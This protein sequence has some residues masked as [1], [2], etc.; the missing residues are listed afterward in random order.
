MLKIDD[1]EDDKIVTF[2]ILG[3]IYSIITIYSFIRLMSTC[4]FSSDSRLARYFYVS[5]FVSSMISTG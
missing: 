2:V 4:K 5:I 1:P 3:T